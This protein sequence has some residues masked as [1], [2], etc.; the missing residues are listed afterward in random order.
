MYGDEGLGVDRLRAAG[1]TVDV[2]NGPY[3]EARSAL[4]SL[5]RNAGS[6]RGRY[7][8]K[9]AVGVLY[10][11][12]ALLDRVIPGVRERSAWIPLRLF[13]AERLPASPE[14]DGQDRA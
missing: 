4:E 11:L 7:R 6:V 1:F 3:F 2:H 8:L 13:Y 9:L 10:P 14:I 5:R 12:G